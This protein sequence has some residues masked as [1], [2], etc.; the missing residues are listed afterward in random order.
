MVFLLPLQGAH[1]A[2]PTVTSSVTS[3]TVGSSITLTGVGFASGAAVGISTILGTATVTWLTAGSCATT[4]GGTGTADSLDATVGG[5][6]CLTTNAAGAFVTMVTVPA[7]TGGAQTISVTD[8]V[9]TPATTSI[10]IKSSI[11]IT[12]HATGKAFSSGYPE[13]TNSVDIALTGF[14]A[15]DSI[16]LTTT[17]AFS[18]TATTTGTASSVGSLTLGT[19]A[20]T[21]AD[22]TGGSKTITATGSSTLSATTSFTIL[23]WV[24]F[25]NTLNGGTTF[26]FLGTAPTSLYVAGHGFANTAVTGG[27][28]TLSGVATS[29]SSFTP[30]STGQFGVGG[31]SHILLSPTA[32][33]PFG[34]VS[35]VIQGNTFSWAAGN[36]QQGTAVSATPVLGGILVSS[37]TS[38]GTGIASLSSSSLAFGSTVAVFGYGYTAAK[39]ITVSVANL[40]GLTI[41]AAAGTTQTA[42]SDTH[43][44]FFET[45]TA[46]TLTDIGAGTYSVAVADGGFDSS[47]S[48]SYTVT[49]VVTTTFGDSGV[50]FATAINYMSAGL[51]VSV[52]GF[53]TTATSVAVTAGGATLATITPTNCPTL[54]TNGGCVGSA[55]TTPDLA[56]QEWTATATDGTNS[57]TTTFSVQP[58]VN[59]NGGNDALTQNSGTAGTVTSLRT[60]GSGATGFGVHGLKASTT[61]SINDG[62][63][64]ATGTNNLGSSF[65]TT[66]TGGIPIPGDQFT[67]PAGTTGIQILTLVTGGVDALWG[68]CIGIIGYA[69]QPT[70]SLAGNPAGQYGDMLFSESASILASPTVANVGQKFSI[71]ATGL[72]AGTVYEETLSLAAGAGN[73]VGQIYGFFTSNS[74]GS[75]PAGT[76]IT[77]PPAATIA[78]GN[79]GTATYAEQGTPFYVHLSTASEYPGAED[80]EGQVVLAGSISLNMTTAPPGHAV[81][82]V[83]TGLGDGCTYDVI[84]NYGTN[85]Q[86]TA[87]TGTL[88]GAFSASSLGSTPGSGVTVTVPSSAIAGTTNVIQLI[89]LGGPALGVLSVPGS[90]TVGSVS[91][92]SCNTTSCIVANGQSTQTIQGA[93]QGISSSFTNNSNAPVTAFVYAV[94]HNALGQTVDIS[95]ATVSA[96]AGGSVTAFNALFGLPPGTYSVS[97]FV[98]SSAGAAISSTSTV[99]VTIP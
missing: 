99:S 30:D 68:S 50:P 15:L 35:V 1:A 34:S 4:N 10:T 62:I 54:A 36:I 79:C 90:L 33:V 81:N 26:S 18:S 47:I 19:D 11:S 9:N 32:N 45:T 87:Y 91:T 7:L 89:R 56:S 25:Y 49:Q 59:F 41:G 97:I 14:G 98:T 58:L 66:A 80:G 22:T 78:L 43:G 8:G 63:I 5:H 61:Y 93:Y 60:I 88:I 76:S 55:V 64:G 53:S 70:S 13:A 31:G 38:G 16:T 82:L 84:F 3:A 48:P 39:A 20:V 95:T 23:P 46:G 29:H 69:C 44:A 77:M 86:A 83:A 75:I 27:S 21:V 92:T 42:T 94:V 52:H 71:S 40:P 2:G 65:T 37:I 51:T 12:T 74:V 6:K 24:A 67:V 28:I 73:A 96:P 17:S 85:P 57:A 72:S